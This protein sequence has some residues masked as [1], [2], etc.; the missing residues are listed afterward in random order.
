MI[1]VLE[2]DLVAMHGVSTQQYSCDLVWFLD[3]CGVVGRWIRHKLLD[4]ILVGTPVLLTIQKHRTN[5]LTVF[6]KMLS[7][8]GTEDF[9][10][11]FIMCLTW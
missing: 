8:L 1:N 10:T 5:A 6:M 7:F 4:G 11:I 9:Y 3:N 2:N